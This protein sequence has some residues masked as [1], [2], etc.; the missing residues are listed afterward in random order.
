MGSGW[1]YSIHQIK[2]ASIRFLE[3][4]VL[5][6]IQVKC[7]IDVMTI[8]R[9][10]KEGSVKKGSCN[11]WQLMQ[12]PARCIHSYHYRIA[13]C[14]IRKETRGMTQKTEE[15]SGFNTRGN[16][17]PFRLIILKWPNFAKILSLLFPWSSYRV[18]LPG[19]LCG[20]GK[21]YIE[22]DSSAFCSAKV[23]RI[24]VGSIIDRWYNQIGFETPN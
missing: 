20:N 14:Q 3:I 18:L 8:L 13:P 2:A 19:G 15:L 23:C 9:A 4:Y 21:V 6:V 22:G 17:L 7:L 24:A 1:L 12:Y 5:H 11:T 10:H 16:S